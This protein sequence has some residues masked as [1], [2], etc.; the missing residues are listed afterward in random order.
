MSKFYICFLLGGSF[1]EVFFCYTQKSNLVE[2]NEWKVGEREKEREGKREREKERERR[3]A[4]LM[5]I[6]PNSWELLNISG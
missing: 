6:T 2:K 1:Y 4:G 3:G 5:I